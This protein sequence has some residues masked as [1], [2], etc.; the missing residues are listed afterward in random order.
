MGDYILANCP[1]FGG[2]VPY[3]EAKKRVILPCVPLFAKICIIVMYRKFR[4]VPLF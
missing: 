4:N 2:T 1:S 3:F